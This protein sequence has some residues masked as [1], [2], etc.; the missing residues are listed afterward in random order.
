MKKGILIR[1]DCNRTLFWQGDYSV[2]HSINPVHFIEQDMIKNPIAVFLEFD[3]TG[4]YSKILW[5][6]KVGW[7]NSN[8]AES[9]E[10]MI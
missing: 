9:A 1:I 8:A 10:N 3:Y 2:S 7:I 5:H 6:G 4:M